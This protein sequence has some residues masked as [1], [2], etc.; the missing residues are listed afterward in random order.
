MLR[1]AEEHRRCRLSLR[2]GILGR[3]LDDL[4]PS[5]LQL[6]LEDERGG[7]QL[8]PTSDR[9]GPQ[10]PHRAVRPGLLVPATEQSG[11]PPGVPRGATLLTQTVKDFPKIPDSYLKAASIMAK[12]QNKEN[13]EISRDL[14]KLCLSQQPDDSRIYNDL[15]VLDSTCDELSNLAESKAIVEEICQ[16]PETDDPIMRFNL[17][18]QAF[19]E[20]G[21]GLT[22]EK[23]RPS[24]G[25]VHSSVLQRLPGQPVTAL[26]PQ[27]GGHSRRK[28]QQRKSTRDLRA[29]IRG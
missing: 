4:Q 29:G 24:F 23:N 12:V 27:L 3:P 2:P 5:Y 10:Q 22:L 14:L 13:Y 6:L 1:N 11:V 19:N 9:H 21:H 20:V 17:A 15:M 28:R 25:N 26:R 8:L 16:R 18:V 7:Q